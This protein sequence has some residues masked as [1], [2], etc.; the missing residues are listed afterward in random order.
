M[1]ERRSLITRNDSALAVSFTPE[2]T[3]MRNTALELSAG[4]GRVA[5]G[6]EQE[7]AVEAQVALKRVLSEVEKS[8]KAAK[9]PILEYG[10]RIDEAVKDFLVDAVDEMT[11]LSKLVGDYQALMEAR[12][13]AAEAARKAELEEA[14]RRRQADLAQAQTHEE[15]DKVNAFHDAEAAARQDMKPPPVPTRAAGQIVRH[16]WDIRV[17]NVHLLAMQHPSLVKITPKLAEIKDALNSGLNVSGVEA[18]RVT[19]STVR[20]GK[21]AKAIEA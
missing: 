2:A 15:A 20:A 8:R 4:I 7:L 1:S 3:R 12:A 16:D 9:T 19:K 10:R 21:E 11:R 13:R 5:N 17:T 18:K 14:E 6:K